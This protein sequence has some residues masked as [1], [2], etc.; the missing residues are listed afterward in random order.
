MTHALQ[1]ISCNN[2]DYYHVEAILQT[3]ALTYY[4]YVLSVD[5][6]MYKT[7]FQAKCLDC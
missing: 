1:E 3:R 4:F 2:F 5:Q 6:G 7:L